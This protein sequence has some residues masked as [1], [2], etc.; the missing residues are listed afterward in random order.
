MGSQQLFHG[1]AETAQTAPDTRPSGTPTMKILFLCTAHNSLSQQ[2]YLTLSQTHTVTVEYAL[3][4]AAM[5]EAAS[6]VQPDIIICPFLT[7]R[8]PS[9]VY[10]KYLT[11]IVHPGPP[12]DAGPSALDWVLM[13]DDGIVT[14]PG[15]LLE[16]QSWSQTGRSH[17]GVTVLQAVAE[18]DAGPVWAFEQ[19]KIDI[20]APGTT[21]SNL[22]RGRVTQAA[23]TATLTALNRI[24]STANGYSDPSVASALSRLSLLQTPDVCG[25]SVHLIASPT[26]R[27]LSVTQRKPFL[28]GVTHRRPLLKA[29]DRNFDV[30]H[31]SARSIS[32]KIR[33][34]DSQ[35]GCLTTLFGGVSLYIY[36]GT[37]EAGRDSNCKHEPGQIIGC[38]D[39]A[40]C[41]ATCDGLGI[42]ITHVR[43]MKRKVDAMLWPKTP[44][45]SG[46]LE[47][48]LIDQ[49][50]LFKTGSLRPLTSWSKVTYSTQQDIWVDF[51]SSAG[52]HRIAFVYFEFYNGAMSTSQCS[53][54][55]EALEFVASHESLDAVVLMGSESYFSNGIAL[56]VI[57][58]SSDPSGESWRNINRID[59]V[60]HMLLD[61]FPRKNVTTVAA[62]RG[63]C[64]AGGVALA[65]ACDVVIAGSESV[66]NPA[67][68]A[69]GLHGSEYHSLSYVGR[70]GP[71][72]SRHI[73]QDMLP[74]T[75]YQAR[76]MGLVDHVL[77]GSGAILD[78]RIRYHV[79]GTCY[80]PYKPGKWKSRVDVSPSGIA[81]A[82]AQELS[83]MA[84]DFW[85]A[86]SER[87]T[88]RRRDFVRKVKPTRTPLRFASHR[89]C[90]GE[91]DEEE[92]DG[93]DDVAVYEERALQKVIGERLLKMDGQLKS[94]REELKAHDDL[95]VASKLLEGKRVTQ[96]GK[97][98]LFP[99]Y[100]GVD[101]QVCI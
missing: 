74:M 3:S 83:E 35:P 70:C 29:A 38:R 1:P 87:Y 60:V 43:R 32:R 78:I 88:S 23:I 42:W 85:S 71:D 44:A 101:T 92:T 15:K 41:I 52:K 63:N 95:L 9:E 54:L 96:K 97:E 25:I 4:D 82:R 81:A 47:L 67:Y 65:A 62:L 72:N 8:V 84:K 2:L 7:T 40:V 77:P 64:A 50:T 73:L 21:K 68:R 19:F 37:I 34:A 46:L 61:T 49:S 56:N 10:S 69:L 89:R 36:G 20:D 58:A 91:F 98:I 75:A 90:E 99:C 45:T 14:E 57:E 93:F 86:R 24:A 94:R 66:L 30:R 79:R 48:G 39:G 100:Y 27:T 17:W 18:M 16:T 55:I 13:G 6:L 31:E 51:A 76:D 80:N 59:D 5:I 11:L 33:S 26:Y 53:R 22:Y 12:G 28:G